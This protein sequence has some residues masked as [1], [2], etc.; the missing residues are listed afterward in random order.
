MTVLDEELCSL[1]KENEIF[2]YNGDKFYGYFYETKDRGYI[3]TCAIDDYIAKMHKTKIVLFI[4][5]CMIFIFGVFISAALAFN[6]FKP[7]SNIL[8][9]ID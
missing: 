9:V 8:K 4:G 6:A 1:V 2:S 3:V 7:I 5:M